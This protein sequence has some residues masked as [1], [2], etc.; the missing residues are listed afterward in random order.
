MAIGMAVVALSF[1]SCSKESADSKKILG[2]WLPS[3]E[4]YFID[5]QEITLE[6]GQCLTIYKDNETDINNPFE[7]YQ[8]QGE[9]SF[10][11]AITIYENGKIEILGFPGSYTI[12]GND[13][14]CNFYGDEVIFSIEGDYLVENWEETITGYVIADDWYPSKDKIIRKEFDGGNKAFKHSSYYSKVN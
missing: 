11:S 9:A 13:L 3:H 1:A 4:K 12:N 2:D 8:C 5:G 14:V 6:Y 10:L 7:L